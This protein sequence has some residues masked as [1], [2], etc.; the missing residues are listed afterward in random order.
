[1][2]AIGYERGMDCIERIL[3][4]GR[5]QRHFARA[6]SHAVPIAEKAPPSAQRLPAVNDR[7]TSTAVST[8]LHTTALTTTEWGALAGIAAEMALE[9]HMVEEVHTSP[10]WQLTH[11]VSAAA[12]AADVDRLRRQARA[13]LGSATPLHP[14]D[15]LSTVSQRTLPATRR[16]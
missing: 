6:E 7:H 5:E 3:T 15:L 13:A 4:A 1:M 14:S 16:H 12:A 2:R 11:R 10:V 9:L 8:R